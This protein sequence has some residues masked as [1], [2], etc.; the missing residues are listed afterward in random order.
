MGPKLKLDEVGYWSEIKLAILEKY[1]RPYNQILTSHSLHSIYIDGF[2]GAG[3]HKAKGSERIILGSP[4]RALAVQPPFEYLHFVDIDGERVEELKRI[5]AEYPNAKVYRGDC[6]DVLVNRIFPTVKYEN[7]ERALCILDPYGLHLN[8]ETIQA[9]GQSR[10]IEIF[11]NFPVMD[12]NM[13]VLWHRS[14]LVSEPQRVRMTKFWGDNSWEQAAYATTAGLFGEMQTKVSNE[15]IADAFRKRLK[16]AGGFKYV[17]KPMP[18]RNTKGATVYFL[19]FAAQ[20]QTASKIV[21]EIFAKYARYGE[22]PNG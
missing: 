8:W 10:V 4:Q 14:E 21:E 7:R 16:S 11:L 9:A 1:A 22:M 12:M 15:D 5:S 19:F 20:Q 3:Q 6:N 17:P 2:A 18:M 13:N